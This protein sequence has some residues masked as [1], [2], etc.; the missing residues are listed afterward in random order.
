[1]AD[2]FR[3][4]YPVQFY[5]IKIVFDSNFVYRGLINNKPALIQVMAL[6]PN[7]AARHQGPVSVLRRPFC[8]G[9]PIIKQGGPMAVLSI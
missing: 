7:K 4:T 5:S 9:I 1:M 6:V 2:I 3:L 8:I